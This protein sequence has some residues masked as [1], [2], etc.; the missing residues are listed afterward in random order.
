MSTSSS[1]KLEPSE[2][3]KFDA[4]MRKILTVSKEELEKAREGM[5]TKTR[6]S[7]E[8]AGSFLAVLPRLT[9]ERPVSGGLAHLY[10]FC[11]GGNVE[12]RHSLLAPVNLWSLANHETG[13]MSPHLCQDRKGGPATCS[14]ST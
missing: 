5:E 14:L 4:V 11:K 2:H 9:V 8:K 6:T 12:F 10:A 13:F 3:E 1:E 7:Q